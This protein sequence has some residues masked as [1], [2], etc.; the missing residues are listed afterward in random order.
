[1]TRAVPG[2]EFQ[3]PGSCAEFGFDVAGFE[4]D[5]SV[6]RDRPEVSGQS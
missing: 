6:F 2:S 3:V 4:V 1:M 5:S